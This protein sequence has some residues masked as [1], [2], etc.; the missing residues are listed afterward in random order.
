MR[1]RLL[2][3]AFALSSVIAVPS[4]NAEQPSGAMLAGACAACHGT[5]GN[6]VSIT[7]SLAGMNQEF[8]IDTMQAFKDGS[9]KATVMDRIAKG[10][11]EA[12]V[13]AMAEFFAAQDLSPMRQPFN[14]AKANTGRELHRQY[15]EKC[16]E[17]GGAK[18]EDGGILAGQSM[19]YLHYSMLD[20]KA[21]DREAP[22]K[23]RSKVKKLLQDHG[24][25]AIEALLHY[26]G[27]QQ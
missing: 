1:R 20:F 4:A 2:A 7:P 8:F 14:Q 17:E 13:G 5:N 19:L 24:G 16:H 25:E 11:S 23:M 22:R 9:R 10:Y 12:D 3:G 27:S 18:S 26:Y 6:S 21:G 15:C